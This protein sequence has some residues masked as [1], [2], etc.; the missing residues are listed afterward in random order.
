[1]YSPSKYPKLKHN[2]YNKNNHKQSISERL[3]GSF[4]VIFSKKSYQ[5]AIPNLETMKLQTIATRRI[6]TP[7][8]Y[9]RTIYQSKIVN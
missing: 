6:E 2:G 5:L 1:M 9:K 8:I 4:F 3:F 7:I